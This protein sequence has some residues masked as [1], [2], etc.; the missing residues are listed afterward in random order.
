MTL[1]AVRPGL[2]QPDIG[3]VLDALAHHR[4]VELDCAVS[5]AKTATIEVR[6]RH[7]L[8]ERLTEMFPFRAHMTP[9]DDPGAIG[10]RIVLV[11][12]PPITG[13][14]DNLSAAIANLLNNALDYIDRWEHHL[15]FDAIHQRYWG[16]VYRLL[17]AGDND[18]IRATLLDQPS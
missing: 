2:P 7:D 11:G 15:R 8:E 3:T 18:H 16:W 6:S 9:I 1:L 10:T 14:G 17:L 5:P 4:P 13:S 12:G